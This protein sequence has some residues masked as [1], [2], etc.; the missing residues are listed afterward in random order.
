MSDEISR[1]SGVGEK[2]GSKDHTKSYLIVNADDFAF[3]PHVSRGILQCIDAGTVGATGI[4]A[5]SAH[6]DEHVRWLQDEDRV[7]IGV[8]LNITAGR[9]LAPAM[10]VAVSGSGGQFNGWPGIGRLFISRAV[11]VSLIVNEWEAQIRRCL[12]A[13]LTIRFLNSHEH[14]HIMPGLF[15]ALVD[16]AAR[17]HVPYVRRSLPDW[18]E[19]YTPGAI[20]RNGIMATMDLLANCT[21]AHPSPRLLGMSVSGRLSMR[22]LKRRL[23]SLRPGR[24]YELMCHP[25]V[26][27]ENGEVAPRL[28]RYHDWE[29]ELALLTSSSFKKLLHVHNVHMVRYRDIEELCPPP[30]A[31]GGASG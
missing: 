8:H 23:S 26:A 30:D 21:P 13:G 31:V 10:E 6:F 5:N 19:A 3:F 28:R 24:V 7:D 20:F 16:L 9:P 22:Y 18:C 4:M 17:F 27:P 1:I 2:H 11:N 14:I 29:S 15:A 12:D 25:G